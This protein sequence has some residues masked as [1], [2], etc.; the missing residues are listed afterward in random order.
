M[1]L[2]TINILAQ[3][4][5]VNTENSNLKKYSKTYFDMHYDKSYKD[6]TDTLGIPFFDDFSNSYIYPDSAKWEDK[7]AFIGQNYAIEPI[8]IGT[9][10]LDALD[11]FGYVYSHLPYGNAA[12]ADYL[13]SRHINLDYLLGDSLYL[14][15]YFQ[16]GGYGN[17][18]EEGDSLVLEFRSPGKDWTSVWRTGGRENMNYFEIV[19][20]P[21]RD[22]IWLQN[23]FQFRFKN[24]VSLTSVYEPSWASN[25]DHWN[26]DFIKLDK[27][28]HINDTFPEDVAFIKN[29]SSLISDFESVPWKHFINSDSITIADSMFFS[30]RYMGTEDGRNI[31]YT[32]KI[33]D[34]FTSDI[35]DPGIVDSENLDPFIIVDYSLQWLFDFTSTVTDS[36]SFEIVMSIN[37]GADDPAI[38]RY[39]D[40]IRYYQNFYNYYAYDDG[41]AEKGYGLSGQGS[42]YAQ[43]AQRWEPLMEDTLRGIYIHFNHSLNEMN[44]NYF[45]LTVWDDKEGVPGDTL[46]QQMGALVNYTDDVYGFFYYPL[47]TLLVID[48]TFYIG[49]IQTTDDNLNVGFDLNRVSNQHLFYNVSGT[50]QNSSIPGSVMMRPVFG[51][52]PY[53]FSTV[54]QISIASNYQIYPNPVN[55]HINFIFDHNPEFIEIY[56]SNG[57][58]V[59]TY[60]YSSQI[61]TFDFPA[62]IYFIRPIG[63]AEV[64]ETQRIIIVK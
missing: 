45:F 31:T 55:D 23:G 33:I 25:V 4:Y 56:D 22:S 27:D 14:S 61:E 44:Q 52:D 18:P 48:S 32:Y 54:A 3:E 6:F 17:S 34:R 29:I 13:T 11:E 7:F 10:T 59:Y 8:S 19:M 62:G 2:N 64:Y 21:I 46:Y 51:S 16:C 35:I 40:T 28:R 58:L 15:F 41:S 60:P 5:L 9:A 43:L 20:I 42:A 37:P 39:N 38:L 50:W 63:K 57:R 47:D 26:L 24:Y 30:N 12:I 49:W 53:P 1:L 36:A